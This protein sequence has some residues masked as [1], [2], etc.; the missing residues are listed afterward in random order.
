VRRGE[1]KRFRGCKV[2]E[3]RDPDQSDG[4]G[5]EGKS[6]LKESP[7]EGEAVS[8]AEGGIKSVCQGPRGRGLPAR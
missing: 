4:G 2:G 1:N 5:G 8:A 3:E 7:E 6:A